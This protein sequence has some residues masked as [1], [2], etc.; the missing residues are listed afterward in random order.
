M[1]GFRFRFLLAANW[2][3]RLCVTAYA[4]SHSIAFRLHF[5]CFLAVLLLSFS[6]FVFHPWFF[7]GSCGFLASP[8]LSLNS[9]RPSFLPSRFFD[10]TAFPS[11][12]VSRQ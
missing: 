1:D 12:N 8:F 2:S 7:F 3:L 4:V 5:A 11:Q 9:G 10:L 6:S